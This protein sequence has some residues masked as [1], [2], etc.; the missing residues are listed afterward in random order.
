MTAIYE[1]KGPAA[2]Y[3]PLACNLYRGCLHGCAYCFAPSCLRMQ[4][5]EFHGSVT[6]RPGILKHLE[7]DADKMV[8]A[9]DTRR[10]LFCF[11]SDPY[12]PFPPGVDVTRQALQIM[13]DRGL[14]FEVC[15]K[16]GLR[17]E[18]DF[19]L[20]KQ[21]GRLGVSLVWNVNDDGEKW[22]PLADL[23]T[24]RQRL[25]MHAHED[26]IPTWVSIEPVIDP[27]SA[28]RVITDLIEPP[29][30][31]RLGKLNPR[32]IHQ[33]PPEWQQRVRAVDWQAFVDEAYDLLVATGKRFLFKE[34]LRPYLRGRAATG[35][36]ASGEGA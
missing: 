2:E 28:L 26:G 17:A 32:T 5:E 27:S 21:G 34:S 29:G 31:F 13:V 3:A 30:E 12:Q 19:D 9:G 6:A 22:E 20:L 11:T 33:L 25:L 10:V 4:R 8:A 23:P 18:R 15:T 36:E 24:R 16:G 1:P 14:N 35:P 7:R